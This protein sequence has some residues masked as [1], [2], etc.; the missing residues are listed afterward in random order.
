MVCR[1]RPLSSTE[2]K[3]GHHDVVECTEDAVLVKAMKVKFDLSPY[4][5]EQTFIFDHV[6]SHTD[7]NEDVY[8]TSIGPLVAS[9]LQ[10]QAKCTCFCFGQTGSGKTYVCM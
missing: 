10:C 1:K 5:E 9:F 4:V 2:E 8:E 3:N 6:F 7:S